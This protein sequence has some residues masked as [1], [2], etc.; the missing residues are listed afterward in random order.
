MKEREDAVYDTLSRALLAGA[1]APGAPLRETALAEVFGVSRER[2]RKIL[3]RLGTNRLIEMIP[4][5]G[6][7][8]AAPSLEQ[9]RS[10]Y[11][12]RRIL[13]GGIVA[14]LAQNAGA[15]ALRRLDEHME[16]EQA[17]LAEGD[18]ATSVR[19]SAD[20]HMILAEATGNTF[21]L[22]QMQ[23]LVSRTSMLVAMYEAPHSAQCACDEHRDIFTSLLK[24][25]GGGAARA[26]RSHLS[27]V[28]TRLRP[29]AAAPSQDVVGV[30]L[31]MW[32]GQRAAQST[33]E[34]R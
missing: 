13:E 19:L 30:L 16:R 8:V 10:I 4:N 17:A 31:R 11:D 25:D 1:L 20:F 14:H 5:R 21:I 2:I 27:L 23:E 15:E 12:A 33:D 34:G 28:E 6:A 22:Q 26:M 24:G 9:A 32:A 18:R 7:F 29:G 3:L